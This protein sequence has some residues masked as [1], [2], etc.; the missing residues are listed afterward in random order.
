MIAQPA[1]SSDFETPIAAGRAGDVSLFAR[2]ADRPRQLRAW[3]RR[4]SK[5]RRTDPQ[6]RC[7][8]DPG[9]PSGSRPRTRDAHDG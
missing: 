3:P 6:A 1:S 7:T 9:K 2:Q 4:L 8:R 5:V